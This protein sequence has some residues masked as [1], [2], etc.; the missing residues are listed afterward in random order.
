MVVT[1]Y[2][3]QD[4]NISQ[5]PSDAEFDVQI[6]GL[7]GSG[8]TSSRLN[9]VSP[10]LPN[11]YCVFSNESVM[12]NCSAK[13]GVQTPN[14]KTS[15]SVYNFTNA[16]NGTY[17]CSARAGCNTSVILRVFGKHYTLLRTVM[18][19]VQWWTLLSYV[20][21]MQFK[22]KW[23]QLIS[24]PTPLPGY[25]IIGAGRPEAPVAITPGNIVQLLCPTTGIE[26]PTTAWQRRVGVTLLWWNL[27]FPG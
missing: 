21:L 10:F 20:L 7:K 4:V 12:F 2:I 6:V 25:I 19:V 8:C 16:D 14:S 22:Q 24:L 17:L 5:L 15:T 27:T 9:P 13:T 18:H 1:M 23:T 11:S 26:N 3:V